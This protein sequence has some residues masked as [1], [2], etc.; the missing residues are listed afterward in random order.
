[1][2]TCNDKQRASF[3]W[4]FQWI[5]DYIFERMLALDENGE[6]DKFISCLATVYAFT[7]T[8]P[9]LLRDTQ[10]STLQPYL[11][12]TERVKRGDYEDVLL[13]S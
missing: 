1:M 4:I 9:D 5:V 6:A 3:K 10:I 7:H 8:C 13:N 2:E 12:V 11:S